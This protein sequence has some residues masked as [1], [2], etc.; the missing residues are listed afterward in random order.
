MRTAI[1]LSA[2]LISDAIRND[3]DL[4]N[5]YRKGTADFLRWCV[6]LFVIADIIELVTL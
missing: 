6:V 4:S 2:I 5:F 3:A 1:I